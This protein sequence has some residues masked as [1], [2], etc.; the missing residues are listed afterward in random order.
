MWIG[1]AVGGVASL[2]VYL[3]YVRDGGPPAKRGLVFSAT[4]TTVGL[5]VGAVFGPMLGAG[6]GLSDEPSRFASI[7]YVTPVPLAGG[8]GFNL[9][10]TLF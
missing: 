8:F 3:F 10:G 7:D 9:G 5:V 4:A 6:I 2:P 1:G